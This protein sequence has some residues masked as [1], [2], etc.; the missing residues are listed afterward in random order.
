[1]PLGSATSGTYRNLL[2]VANIMPYLI[3]MTAVLARVEMTEIELYLKIDAG[4]FPE[5]VIS[6][7]G[8][9]AFIEAEVR[10]WIDAFIDMGAWGDAAEALRQRE[11]RAARFLRSA[12]EHFSNSVSDC[13]ATEHCATSIAPEMQFSSFV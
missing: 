3:S 10:A 13:D 7:L 5:P 12:S 1:M 9:F 6:N 4:E 2:G 8:Q 11:I